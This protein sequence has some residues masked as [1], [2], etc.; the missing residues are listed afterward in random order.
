MIVQTIANL[1]PGYL[2]RGRETSYD[3]ENSSG[4]VHQYKKDHMIPLG[5]L[6]QQKDKVLAICP[7]QMVTV[8][9][10]MIKVLEN[11]KQ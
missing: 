2:S 11:I 1:C 4:Q 9:V 3:R 10:Q 8:L 7:Q 5:I 6:N